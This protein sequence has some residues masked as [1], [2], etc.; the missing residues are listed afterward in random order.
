MDEVIQN[1]PPQ[2]SFVITGLA[3]QAA[4]KA[5]KRQLQ[6]QGRK[7]AT[8]KRREIVFLVEEYLAQ[9]R[10]ALL[11][12]TWSGF[13]RRQN[14]ASYMSESSGSFRRAKL[15]NEMRVQNDRGLRSPF[16]RTDRRLMLSKRHW[17]Q[18]PR[19]SSLRRSAARSQIER[20]WPEQSRR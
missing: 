4:I 18:V 17:R 20:H 19:R 3:R 9:H 5:V 1:I 8:M 11:A 15:V 2:P 14:C 10:D 6:A 12:Q 7:I 16:R 13:A